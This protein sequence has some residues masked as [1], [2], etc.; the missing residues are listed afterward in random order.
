MAQLKSTSIAGDL[1]VTGGLSA[2]TILKIGG[3]GVQVLMAD[4]SVKTVSATN[5]NNTIVERDANGN[6]AAASF[7]GS[8]A[9]LTDL[10]INN[11][12][13]GIL[14]IE[15]G[16]TGASTAADARANLGAQATITGA[17]TTVTSSNLTASKALVSNSSGKIAVSAVTSTELG[18]L[19][20][21][22]SN[23]QTQLNNK[24]SL[25]GGTMTGAIK[26]SS[27][28]TTWVAACK[29]DS[30]IN[31]THATPGSFSPMMS[32]PTT[33]GRMALAFYKENLL[34]SYLTKADCDSNTNTPTTQAILFNESGGAEWSGT[35]KASV[36]NSTDSITGKK[37][38]LTNTLTDS[39]NNGIILYRAGSGTNEYMR[40]NTD[41]N[42]GTITNTNETLQSLINIVLSYT[43]DANSGAG[44]GSQTI[45]LKGTK[46]GS[47][48]TATKFN[49]TASKVA[50][51]LSINGKTYNGSSAI[52]VGTIGVGYGGTG[53]TA[54]PSLQV[55]L[56]STSAVSIFTASPRPGVTGTL[57]IAN[58]GTGASSMTANRMV[59]TNE[60]GT[61]MTSGY[62]YVDSGKV[63]IACR[64]NVPD[65]TFYVGTEGDK[66]GTAAKGTLGVATS[67]TVANKATMKYD[68]TNEYLYFT[69]A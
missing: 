48:I 18:Y 19:D 3:T 53:L 11:V 34:V 68:T 26:R 25:S 66:N 69:F 2:S 60:T 36:F 33:N 38:I 14:S 62:H 51:N 47:E 7:S 64:T 6:I 35:V 5:T 15:H 50:N 31:S 40:I 8:G 24:L 12:T 27:F 21:V 29:S 52:N 16:G 45:V 28:P 61:A 13:T 17:A 1:S 39:N 55:N 37:I 57:G 9:N 49:G 32:G 67:I 65:Y 41:A 4:G 10:N 43:D 63:A 30:L 44:K 46:D 22:T 58:G 20:G 59:F 56:A 54:A 23:V 42:N